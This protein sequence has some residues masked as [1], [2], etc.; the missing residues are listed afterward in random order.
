MKPNVKIRLA[1]L[2]LAPAN[3]ITLT[4]LLALTLPDA[5][6]YNLCR[7]MLLSS[8]RHVAGLLVS[9]GALEAHAALMSVLSH[10]VFLGFL[11]AVILLDI[12]VYR[13]WRRVEADETK[14]SED[15]SDQAPR[16]FLKS[17]LSKPLIAVAYGAI[18]GLLSIWFFLWLFR[19]FFG[20]LQ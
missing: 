2:A 16:G 18:V 1:I 4:S 12:R 6:A 19:H 5:P 15:R 11:V 14:S 17:L 20:M 10:V 7:A 13:W 3:A 9:R 8:L